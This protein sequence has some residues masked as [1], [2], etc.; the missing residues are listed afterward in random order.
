VGPDGRGLAYV[1]DETGRDD[2]FVT[3]YPEPGGRVQISVAGA[4]SPA[5]SP[6]SKEL[7]YFERDGLVA[8][9]IATEPTLRVVDCET[10]FRGS[11]SQYRW[12]RQYDVHPDGDKFVM[13]ESPSGREVEIVVNWYT[14]LQRLLP[15]TER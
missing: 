5:W 10:L 14:E 9:Q 13:L 4:T 2:V 1:S 15:T 3:S 6:D 11:L 8:A 12:Q 7:H